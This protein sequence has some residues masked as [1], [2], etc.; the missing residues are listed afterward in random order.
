MRQTLNKLHS[1]SVIDFNPPFGVFLLGCTTNQGGS[2]ATGEPGEVLEG[3][4]LGAAH[5]ISYDL[6]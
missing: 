5:F 3:K 4:I 1:S 2:K 6:F